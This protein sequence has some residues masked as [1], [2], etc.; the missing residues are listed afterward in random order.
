MSNVTIFKHPLINHKMKTIRDENTDAKEFSTLLSEVAMLMTYEVTKD[1][2]TKTV[3]VKTPVADAKCEVLDT[4]IV[5]VPI[6]RAGLG[7]LEGFQKLMDNVE[8][9]FIGMARDEKTHQPVGYFTKLPPLE[10]KVVYVLDPM[11]A[12]GGSACDAIAKLKAHGATK[13]AYIG[14]VG[15]QEGIDKIQNNHPDVDIYLA[16]LDN[17]L[18]ENAY[19][20]PGLGDCGDRLFGK[21]N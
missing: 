5:L 11:L 3:Y 18:N 1:L 12:T 17:S 9:G 7:F 10:H 20:V 15:A 8:V 19:I 13:I 2:R 21:T 6:L 14:L 4:Q 16:N